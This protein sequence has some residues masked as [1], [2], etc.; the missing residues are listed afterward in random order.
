[1]P[2][3]LELWTTNLQH[4]SDGDEEVKCGGSFSAGEECPARL[5]GKTEDAQML[6]VMCITSMLQGRSAQ[7]GF[8][9]KS[10]LRG[11]PICSIDKQGD[12]GH[13]PGRTS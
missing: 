5:P 3:S 13:L 2:T 1:M 12:V 6:S 8:P 10:A 4:V 9:G 11:S 7:R